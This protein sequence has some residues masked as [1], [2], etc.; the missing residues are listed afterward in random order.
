MVHHGLYPAIGQQVLQVILQKIRHSDD[1]HLASRLR[2]LQRT[3]DG[4]VLCK[5]AFGVP[6]FVPRL[7]C[8]DDH[9]VQ[10]VQPHFFQRFLNR[11][12]CSLIGFQ[13]CG[14]FACDKQLLTGNA[15]ATDSLANALLI[16]VG[17]CSINETIPQRNSG[18]DCLRCFVI[19]NAPCAKPQFGDF[20]SIFQF[21]GFL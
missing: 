19:V 11:G 5:V 15:A 20:R 14:H 8:M 9:L 21:V 10:I 12:G 16:F 18:A 6:E 4:F 3:P 7:G 1:P 2:I 17:L 13:F